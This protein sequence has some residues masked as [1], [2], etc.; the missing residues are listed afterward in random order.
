MS[1]VGYVGVEFVERNGS[2][3]TWI[4]RCPFCKQ[5]VVIIREQRIMKDGCVNVEWCVKEKC[6][7]FG[8]LYPLAYTAM[9]F[10]AHK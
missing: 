8:E 5:Y 9:F 2:R 7:H 4:A 3:E 1:G 10:S 6:E